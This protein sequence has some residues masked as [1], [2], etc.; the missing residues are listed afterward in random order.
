MTDSP[1]LEQSNKVDVVNLAVSVPVSDAMTTLLNE[2]RQ[3]AYSISGLV[4]TA[5]P[6]K[7]ELTTS[8]IEHDSQGVVHLSQQSL[9]GVE[10]TSSGSGDQ[11]YGIGV[12]NDAM[13]F[14][15]DKGQWIRF[16]AFS[17]DSNP[18]SNTLEM[19]F[20]DSDSATK[21][22]LEGVGAGEIYQQADKSQSMTIEQIVEA[23][24]KKHTALE[25]TT[26]SDDNSEAVTDTF[27]FKDGVN[28]RRLTDPGLLV[29]SH[30][31][32]VIHSDIVTSGHQSAFH[33]DIQPAKDVA[34]P[35]LDFDSEK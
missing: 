3:G 29:Q 34:F 6:K 1:T 16:A 21:T 10:S 12:V 11:Y 24:G 9:H 8:L 25:M 35:K 32:G 17:M 28:P 23:N 4:D 30:I 20:K 2:G 27:V 15:D 7:T 26:K 14:L 19:R 5:N 22:S 31:L 13:S 18:V 33:V